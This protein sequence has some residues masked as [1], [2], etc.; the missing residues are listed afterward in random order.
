MQDELT[1]AREAAARYFESIPGRVWTAALARNI[2]RGYE[3]Q[4]DAVQGALFALRLD[5]NVA[6]PPPPAP[7]DSGGMAK[8]GF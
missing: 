6:S 2:R 5:Q 4:L 3:D 1:R 8:K 7:P